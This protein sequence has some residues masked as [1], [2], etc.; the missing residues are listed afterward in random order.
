MGAHQNEC[1]LGSSG[2][3]KKT[4]V[5]PCYSSS[6][7][8]K[9]HSDLFHHL[10]SDAKKINIHRVKLVSEVVLMKFL[11]AKTKQCGGESGKHE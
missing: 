5:L 8:T 9:H 2:L 3:L 10:L 7:T 4:A 11:N 1:V 6:S